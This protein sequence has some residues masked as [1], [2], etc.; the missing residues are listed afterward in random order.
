[1]DDLKDLKLD[2]LPVVPLE[3][4]AGDVAV[5]HPFLLHGSKSNIS[6]LNRTSYLNGYVKAENCDR[7]EWGFKNGEPV[8]LGEPQLVQFEGL[9]ER[10][11]PHYI[12]GAPHKFSDSKS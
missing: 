11:E 8:P 4:A 7:G 12:N 2:H 5:W 10:P 3:L 9:Y 1:M 6:A